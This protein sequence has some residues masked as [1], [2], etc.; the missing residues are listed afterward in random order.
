M[1]FMKPKNLCPLCPFIIA[2]FHEFFPA[3]PIG[4]F[5]G[6]GGLY[7]LINISGTQNGP[8]GF[9]TLKF[10]AMLGVGFPLHRPENIQLI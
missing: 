6:K 7:R 5:L 2:P 8:E 1:K 3:K 9:L 4:S 10:S